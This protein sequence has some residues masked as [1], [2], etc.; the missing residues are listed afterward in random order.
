[1][2]DDVIDGP[3]P[4]HHRV[5]G[6]VVVSMAGADR[7]KRLARIGAAAP[8]RIGRELDDAQDG[9]V[10]PRLE[11]HR[12]VCRIFKAGVAGRRAARLP[13]VGER[14]AGHRRHLLHVGSEAVCDD[15]GIAT[16][17]VAG[18]HAANAPDHVTASL[19]ATVRRVWPVPA[20]ARWKSHSRRRNGAGR[21]SVFASAGESTFLNSPRRYSYTAKP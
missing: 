6:A 1:Q 8:L 18:K 12:P 15:G 13:Q 19:A 10:L 5:A 17:V 11:P 7:A 4:V 21:T 20:G 9:A 2:H 16:G 14:E 3:S